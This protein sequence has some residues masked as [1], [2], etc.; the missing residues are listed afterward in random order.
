[1]IS[2]F[3]VASADTVTIEEHYRDGDKLVVHVYYDVAG[4]RTL[5]LWAQDPVDETS[6]YFI[7]RKTVSGKGI[8]TIVGTCCFRFPNRYEGKKKKCFCENP[9]VRIE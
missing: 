7:S 9:A 6:A 5:E 4:T 1:M 8:T 2:S 3:G